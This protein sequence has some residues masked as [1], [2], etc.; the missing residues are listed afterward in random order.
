ME[1]YG[2]NLVISNV[3]SASICICGKY[4][5]KHHAI[6]VNINY[7]IVTVQRCRSEAVISIKSID[8]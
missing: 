7:L 2:S 1:T 8:N 4:N 6:K 3:W 5:N